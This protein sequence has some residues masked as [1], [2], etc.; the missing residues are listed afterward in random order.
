[1]SKFAAKRIKNKEFDMSE[2]YLG[3]YAALQKRNA[4][5][6]VLDYSEEEW[7]SL[8]MLREADAAESSNAVVTVNNDNNPG[9]LE[10]ENDTNGGDCNE[11]AV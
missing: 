10:M 7:Q 11:E 9:A 2:T 3:R 1:M 5:A 8:I 6:A 4:V